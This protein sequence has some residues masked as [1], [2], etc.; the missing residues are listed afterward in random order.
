QFYG[1]KD[2][3][4]EDVKFPINSKEVTEVLMKKGLPWWAWVLIGG[5]VV[6]GIMFIIAS[7]QISQSGVGF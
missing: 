7:E 5:A 3:P 4:G 1:I 6:I 2:N